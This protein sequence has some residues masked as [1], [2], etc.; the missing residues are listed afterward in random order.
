MMDATYDRKEIDSDPISKRA[1]QI[2][3]KEND[4]APIGWSKYIPRAKIEIENLEVENKKLRERL[5]KAVDTMEAVCGKVENR[6]TQ[7][8]LI[9]EIMKARLVLSGGL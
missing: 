6:G 1:F 5:L 4:N 7:R 9:S 8:V 3:E 2:S